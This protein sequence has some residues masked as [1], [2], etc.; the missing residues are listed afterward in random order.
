[1]GAKDEK[2]I[3]GSTERPEGNTNPETGNTGGHTNGNS[4][5]GNPGTGN[6]GTGGSTGGKA[7]TGKTEEKK[8]VQSGLLDV[9]ETAPTPEPPKKKQV[10]KKKPAKKKVEEK[11]AFDS[12]QLSALIVSFSTIIASR[13]NLE[14]FALSP[15][16]AEQIAT[17]LSNIFAKSEKLS[18]V[19]EHSDAIALVTACLI[20]MLPRVMMYLDVKKQKKLKANG[21]VKIA[22]NRNSD[23]EKGKGAGS[24]RKASRPATENKQNDADGILASIPALV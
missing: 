16:E 1:M 23:N 4:S 11:P 15:M 7:G 2:R 24:D 21:G 3:S 22:D 18:A 17:P 13:P 20:I 5:S 19:S 14:M 6:T 9:T 8:S 10:R 12:S